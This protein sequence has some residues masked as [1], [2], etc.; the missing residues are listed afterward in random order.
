[1][2]AICTVMDKRP[3]GKKRQG[4]GKVS[5]ATRLIETGEP[6]SSV[7]AGERKEATAVNTRGTTRGR[8]VRTRGG[9][10][11]TKRGSGRG[12]SGASKGEGTGAVA[13]SFTDKQGS[14][15]CFDSFY[16]FIILSCTLAFK[17]LMSICTIL[18]SS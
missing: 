17:L 5:A 14:V 6:P 2:S 4:R 12:G 18:I 15:K 10:G 7:T 9:R 16:S 3:Y 11:G 8:T 13:P 1:M